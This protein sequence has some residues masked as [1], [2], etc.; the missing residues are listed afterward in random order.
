[1][2]LPRASISQMSQSMQNSVSTILT[3]RKWA[4][5]A[6]NAP[7]AILSMRLTT[8]KEVMPANTNC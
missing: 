1:M 4:W 8:T 7:Q 5:S 6:I 2:L 3:E